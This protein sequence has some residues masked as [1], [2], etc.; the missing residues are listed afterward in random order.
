SKT[1]YHRTPEIFCRRGK[2]VAPDSISYFIDKKLSLLSPH[3]GSEHWIYFKFKTELRFYRRIL[4]SDGTDFRLILSFHNRQPPCS[5]R[6]Q[7][8]SENNRNSSLSQVTPVLTMYFHH[9]RFRASHILSEGYPG[10]DQLVQEETQCYT[11]LLHIQQL[12]C[13]LR[14]FLSLKTSDLNIKTTKLLSPYHIQL[15]G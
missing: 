9:L 6:I 11:I 1:P 3:C 12:L 13:S 4:S 2:T 10:R 7:D 5:L 15:S 14:N 8:G